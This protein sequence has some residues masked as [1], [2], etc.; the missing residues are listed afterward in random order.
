[1]SD[2]QEGH[3]KI[4]P[5]TSEVALRTIFP[6]DQGP[7]LAAMAWLV[8][9]TNSGARSAKTEE[10]EGEDWE[11]LYEPPSVPAPPVLSPPVPPTAPV[12]SGTPA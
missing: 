9:T 5:E 2:Y 8:S 11:D 4:N 3:V 12:A 7:Q 10:V 6:E 1:M